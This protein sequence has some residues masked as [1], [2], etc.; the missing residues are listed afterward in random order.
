MNIL[1]TDGDN[2]ASLAIVRSLGNKGHNLFVGEIKQPS[3]ASSSKFCKYK[4]TYPNPAIN[5]SKFI[6]RIFQ[7]VKKNSIDLILPVRDLT[8]LSITENY[9][10]F[11]D[12]CHIPFAS[13]D[14]IKLAAS[15]LKIVN[16]AQNINISV[17]Q[18][19]YLSTPNDVDDF[20]FQIP[21]PIV[22]KSDR[23]RIRIDNGILSTSV[24][25]ANNKNELIDIIKSKHH[26]EFPILLQ[27]RVKGPGL[28][29]FVCYNHGKM[30]AYF[31][32]KRLREKPP[33]GG[34][35]TLR[36]SV[37][38]HPLALDYTKKLMDKLIWHGVAMV[39]FK[40]DDRD[41]IPKLM[42]INGRF[43]G[44]LQLAID[45]GMDFP[46]ILINTF[47]NNQIE[48]SQDY[49]IGI[50]TRWFLGDVDALISVL[51]KNKNKLNLPVRFDSK[52]IYL[53]KF[54]KLYQKNMYYEIESLTDI[55]PCLYELSQ[56]ILRK[57]K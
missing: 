44:S 10:Y 49:K 34:V 45:A 27:E 24:S 30:I 54:L 13:S 25:Y 52:F 17:P 23:S 7:E 32:H 43:W 20:D 50:K 18:T 51:T 2:R 38:I 31:G 19:Q 46:E 33:S 3:L 29:V 41:G 48:I 11:K 40:L 39:E 22:I 12:I 9:D 37:A 6:E 21:F 57:S 14:S 53:M 26:N 16:L 35:S 15:K 1:I 55:G 5:E 28:G 36:E 8:T 56:W 42:E 47:T 4:F